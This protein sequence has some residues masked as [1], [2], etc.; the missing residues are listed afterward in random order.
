MAADALAQVLRPLAQMFPAERFPELLVGLGPSDDAAVYKITDEVALVATL[1]FITPIVDDPYQFGAIAAANSLSDIYAMGG[2]PALALN[3]S[4]LSKCLPP[5]VIS[6]ILRG[7][8]EQVLE[9]GAVLVGGHSVDDTEPK[10]GLVAL[11]FVHPTRIMTKAVA[12]PGDTIILT[13]PLGVGIITT[14]A[15]RDLAHP[16]HLAAATDSMLR[17]NAIAAGVLSAAGV[18]CCTDVTGFALLGHASEIAEKSGVT[19]RLRF[20]GIPFLPGARDYAQQG[21][22][23]GGAG[24]NQRTFEAGIAWAP[25]TDESLRK[26]LFTPETS[27]GLLST[28]PADQWPG[29]EAALHAA[30]QPFWVLGEVVARSG[31]RPLIE[32]A[33]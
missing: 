1:D 9:A 28:I 22:F 14:A 33:S 25:T 16:E 18:R 15:K 29:V 30:Q 3:I 20:E 24:K 7:G 27:G 4:C 12:R 6:E 2:R 17:L 13:K 21:L 8:A 32:F 5:D 23:P 10:Y 11:G 31:P 26:L 19:L